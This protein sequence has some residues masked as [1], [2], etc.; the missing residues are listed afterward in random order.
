MKNILKI[1][2]LFSFLFLIACSNESPSSSTSASQTNSPEAPNTEQVPLLSQDAPVVRVDFTSTGTENVATYL[3]N[4]IN[5]DKEKI[6]AGG[7]TKLEAHVAKMMAM[8]SG[9]CA[10]AESDISFALINNENRLVGRYELPCAY[11]RKVYRMIGVGPTTEYPTIRGSNT[12]IISTN[13][14]AIS[15]NNLASFKNIV[16]GLEPK[17]FNGTK[18]G[19]VLK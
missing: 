10:Q 18:I 15:A 8:T 12:E 13:R 14:L 4:S 11:V 5:I 19:E 16:G 7:L 2:S 3:V 6:E 1:A 17:E 9:K